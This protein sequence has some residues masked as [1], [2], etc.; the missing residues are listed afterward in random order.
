MGCRQ[1]HSLRAVGM[2]AT[3]VLVVCAVLILKGA[4]ALWCWALIAARDISDEDR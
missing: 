1:P 4:G 3:T 2:L